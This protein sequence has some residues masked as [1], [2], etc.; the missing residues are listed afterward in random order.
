[1]VKQEKFTMR[2]TL[3]KILERKMIEKKKYSTYRRKIQMSRK[4]ELNGQKTEEITTKFRSQE[5]LL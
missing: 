3:K 5:L 1:M 2:K 4:V